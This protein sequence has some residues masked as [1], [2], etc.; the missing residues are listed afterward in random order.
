M[1]K[2]LKQYLMNTRSLQRIN[3]ALSKGAVTSSLREIDPTSPSSWEFSAFSQNG[4]DGIIDYLTTKVKNSNRYFIEIGASNGIENNTAWLSVA[5]KYS[6]IMIEGVS[7]LSALSKQLMPTLNLGLEC[8]SMFV[9]KQN[10]DELKSI[11]RYR[12]PDLFSI[13]IDGND[14]YV[15]EALL[16]GG[17]RPKIFVVEYNS[18]FGPEKSITIKYKEDFN[19]LEAHPTNLYFGV[20]I[21]GWKNLFKRFGYKFITVEKNGANAFFVDPDAF[22]EKFLGNIKGLDYAE[23]FYHAR[24]FKVSWEKQFEMIKDMDFKEIQ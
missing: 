11:A 24:N 22:D 2:A 13:D 5:R 4:E 19:Y 18:A 3:I 20:S 16:E 21:A 17:F 1:I 6:G 7:K 8:L 14:F 12:D 9:S 10:I 23:N 15:T